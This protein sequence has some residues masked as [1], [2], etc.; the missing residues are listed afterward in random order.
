M[1]AIFFGTPDFAVPSLEAMLESGVGVD[2]VV[3]RPD[4]PVGRH[5][6]PV[7][8][9]VARLA[10]RRGLRVTNPERV[11][12]NEALRAEI[13]ALRPDVGVVVAYGR[14]L[15]SELLEIPRHGFV[16]V[17]AS[18]LPRWRGAAPVAAAILAGD[19]ETGVVTMR[20]EEELDAGPLYLE[21]RT[22][23]G[24]SETATTL[25][26]RLAIEGGSLLVETLRGLEGGT[27]AGR[28]Q[29]GEATFCRPL[30][31]EDGEADWS[32]PADELE[33]RLRAFT[34][35][36]GLF[37]FLGE[38]RI[39][40]LEARV[41]PPFGGH[42]GDVRVEGER[43]LVAA[44]GGTSLEV[45]R[46]QRAGRSAVSGSELARSLP[47]GARLGRAGGRSGG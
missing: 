34:P 41:G 35:W 45:L 32:R 28:A 40:I 1:R 44:G 37:T 43:P 3:T 25:S 11:R 17:H 2:M 5:S 12:S 31:R 18:L 33:R 22:A 13:R 7:A 23:I 27:L 8:S 24:A 10:Q 9:P 26:G 42:P 29:Q 36:P 38:D 15:P 20:V 21:R 6:R 16:N 39:K 46:A 4:R 47:P 14:I 30:R 19:S